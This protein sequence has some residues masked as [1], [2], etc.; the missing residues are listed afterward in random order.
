MECSDCKR[1]DIKCCSTC[2][3]SETECDVWHNCG[4]DCPDWTAKKQTNADRIRAMSDEELAELIYSFEDLNAPDYCL[5]KK[6]CGYMLNDNIIIPSENCQKCLL[7][8]LKQE[9]TP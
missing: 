2:N 9:V 8:W 5:R 3:S 1:T 7:H 4:K 6:E